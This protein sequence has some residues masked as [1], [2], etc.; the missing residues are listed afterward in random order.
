MP[1]SVQDHIEV[2]DELETDVW[3]RQMENAET[4]ECG[5]SQEGHDPEHT[6][7]SC[8]S[9]ICKSFI[10]YARLQIITRTRIAFYPL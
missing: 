4:S 7:V 2:V 8:T 6:N 9:S 10:A 3:L 1:T 5:D